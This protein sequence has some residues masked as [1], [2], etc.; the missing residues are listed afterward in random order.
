[1]AVD[2]I[3]VRIA[4]KTIVGTVADVQP[5]GIQVCLQADGGARRFTVA[6]P[7]DCRAEVFNYLAEHLNLAVPPEGPLMLSEEQATSAMKLAFEV[8]PRGRLPHSSEA[9]TDVALAV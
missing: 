6:L 8:A 9:I 5:H 2:S 7:A 4:I 1:M 3:S